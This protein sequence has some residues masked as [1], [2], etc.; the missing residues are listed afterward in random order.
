MKTAD[1]EGEVQPGGKVAKDV[2]EKVL[3]IGVEE[4]PEPEKEYP[5]EKPEEK[6]EKTESWFKRAR[7]NNLVASVINPPL[8]NL[9]LIPAAFVPM[10]LTEREHYENPFLNYRERIMEKGDNMLGIGLGVVPYV[11]SAGGFP[12]ALAGA[13]LNALVSMGVVASKAIYRGLRSNKE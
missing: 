11:V 10:W 8:S 1:V 13:G 6:K 7:N 2:L 12:I 9:A 3:H 5:V 4:K